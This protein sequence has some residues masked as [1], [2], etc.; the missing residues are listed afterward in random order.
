MQKHHILIAAGIVL[1]AII[2]IYFTNRVTT[3]LEGNVT[4]VSGDGTVLTLGNAT[5]SSGI[6]NNFLSVLIR[7]F[8]GGDISRNG[9]NFKVV[10]SIGI[11]NNYYLKLDRPINIAVG[12]IVLANLH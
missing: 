7:R 11:G 4:A 10:C 2:V 8:I 3:G 9:V 6:D 12:E 1:V 5:I